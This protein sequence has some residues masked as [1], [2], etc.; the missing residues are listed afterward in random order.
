MNNNDINEITDQ[1]LISVIILL[2]FLLLFHLYYAVKNRSIE[3]SKLV[4]IVIF[5][6]VFVNDMRIQ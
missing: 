4:L 1:I 3:E 5:T 6:I 2:S